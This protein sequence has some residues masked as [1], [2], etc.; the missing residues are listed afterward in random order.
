MDQIKKNRAIRWLNYLLLIINITALITL[1]FAGRTTTTNIEQKENQEL[2]VKFLKERLNL[3][4]SQYQELI[5]LS[6]KTFRAYHVNLD[7]LCEANITL[8]EEM[9]KDEVNHEEI[10]K[11]V[12][13]IGN[14]NA[15][16]KRNTVKHFELVKS[17]CTKEQ[18]DDLVM[19]FKEIMQL[20]QQ[21]EICNRKE[22]PRKERLNNIGKK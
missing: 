4:E 15:T 21:C 17:I 12:K 13:K 22:C 8:L 11:I 20:E 6:E 1:L 9:S 10:E 5:K 14:I 19:I 18:K 2:S 7:L 3:S 16:L